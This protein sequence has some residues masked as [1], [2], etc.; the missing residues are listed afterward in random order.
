[1]TEPWADQPMHQRLGERLRQASR[2]DVLAELRSITRFGIIVE[3]EM[4]DGTSLLRITGELTTAS[5]QPPESPEE[6]A[7]T[8][9]REDALNWADAS[10]SMARVKKMTGRPPGSRPMVRWFRVPDTVID[11][12]AGGYRFHLGGGVKLAVALLYL[13]GPAARPEGWQ[14]EQESS[15]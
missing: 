1:M 5:R 8:A 3:L 6:F 15:P 11:E 14:P 13:S 2:E 12:Y 10:D 7:I 4:P 9:T